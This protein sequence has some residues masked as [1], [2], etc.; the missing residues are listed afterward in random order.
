MKRFTLTFFTF[1]ISTIIVMAQVDTQDQEQ[2]T[3]AQGPGLSTPYNAIYTHFEFLQDYNYHPEIAAQPFIQ[4]GMDPQ[5]AQD[6]A[7]KLKHIFDGRIIYLDAHE[8]PTDPNY[9]DSV[10]LKNKYVLS[11]LIPE[12]YVVKVGNQW[13]Y[14]NKTIESIDRLY[15][16]TYPYGTDK[17][18]TWLPKI[19]NDKY[20]GLYI[21]QL[22][23]MLI[24]VL[25]S[26]L[27]HK[28]FTF[29][30]EKLISRFFVKLGRKKLAKE[31]IIP[32]AKPTSL[33][34]V[35]W[36]LTI[37]VP[38]LQLP[39]NT[40]Y[41]YIVLGLKAAQA[42]FAT[43][44]FYYLVDLISEYF[45]RLAEKT[46]TTLDDQLVPLVRKA[47]KTF[48]VIVGGFYVLASLNVPIIPV[49]TGLSIGGLAF[50]LAAQDTIKNFFGSFMIFVDKP[51][52]I[53]DW[54]TTS[55]ID[56][57]VE[58]VGFRSTRV[59]TFRNSV[60]YVPNGNLAD[61]TVDNHGLRVFRR[62]YTQIAI[63][64]DTPAPLIQIFVD[65]LRKIVENHPDTR[66]DN[67][68]VYLNNMADSSLNVMFYI[69]FKVPDWG[70]EL[71]ARHEV[72][73]QI[74]ELADELGVRF[75]F[76]T[77]TL[78][79]EEFPGK[80]SM[81]PVYTETSEDMRNKM[82]AFLDKQKKEG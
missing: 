52:Q 60:V 26:F 78:H 33:F 72:I 45:K 55:D 44:V 48:V 29:L 28:I 80:P 40:Y 16:E 35:F 46:E 54:I 3:G 1:I 14:S 58:E 22:V 25:I 6:L 59:R 38:A 63:T 56:G 71:R 24:L 9:V 34:V 39:I 8:F 53:G 51:F 10:S 77:Q 76:N 82:L 43:M 57:T 20:L 30:F 18:L 5:R 12:I 64:Y 75:A 69:F 81:T 66:K 41:K 42:V 19:G 70:E 17:L 15:K 37:L 68:H 74:I 36:L 2:Q 13:K 21:W 50:A 23:G 65:G 67:Y 79:M 7:I 4:T 32:V 61:S 27:I 47:L 49:L 31:L 73:M 11:K 62:F